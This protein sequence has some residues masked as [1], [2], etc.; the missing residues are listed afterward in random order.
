MLSRY[1]SPRAIAKGLVVLIGLAVIFWTL[2]SA[3]LVTGQSVTAA[4]LVAALLYAS[5]G[6]VTGVFAG[7]HQVL[8]ALAVGLLFG[9]GIWL[10]LRLFLAETFDEI[11]M[12]ADLAGMGATLFAVLACGIGGVVS[13]FA[14]FRRPTS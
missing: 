13:V 3:A 7:H 8:N 14:P 5:G 12:S 10:A 1:L 4:I 9:S 2:P 6:Y 11:S